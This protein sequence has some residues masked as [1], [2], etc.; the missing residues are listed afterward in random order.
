MT[1]KLLHIAILLSI[2]GCDPEGD[3]GEYTPFEPGICF[4]G[5]TRCA[6]NREITEHVNDWQVEMYVDGEWVRV[7][8]CWEFPQFPIDNVYTTC[9]H[10]GNVAF[11]G[12]N[13]ACTFGNYTS[14]EYQIDLAMDCCQY[15]KEG[16]ALRYLC[17]HL[18]N[19]KC[20]EDLCE[21]FIVDKP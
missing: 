1:H 3:R 2:V 18:P 12:R 14:V 21:S 11:C 5:S 19:S 17:E 8:G 13:A 20:A 15:F 4:E 9:N 10:I 16:L 6:R 7:F